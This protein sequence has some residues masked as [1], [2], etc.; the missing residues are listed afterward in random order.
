MKQVLTTFLFTM[1]AVSQARADYQCKSENGEEL[2]VKLGRYHAARHEAPYRNVQ[3]SFKNAKQTQFFKG[4]FMEESEHYE[5][6]DE[7]GSSVGLKVVQ[8]I[9]LGGRCGR[10]SSH[11][12]PS[13]DYPSLDTKYF[14][15]LFLGQTEM[16]FQCTKM[17]K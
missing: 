11:D 2:A 16:D 13:S 5:L 14:A 17:V 1:I 6:Y 7:N 12:Y 8:S 9:S 4:K 3:V 15:K 10:C